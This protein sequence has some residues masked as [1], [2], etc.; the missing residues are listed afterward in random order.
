MGKRIEKSRVKSASISLGATSFLLVLFWPAY[1][2]TYTNYETKGTSLRL[3]LPQSSLREII[4][5]SVYVASLEPVN[6][7]R[8][9]L[10]SVGFVNLVSLVASRLSPIATT[11]P[12]R[13]SLPLFSRSSFFFDRDAI[14]A[15]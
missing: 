14:I 4:I 5:I 13:L 12:L 3:M 2:V 9:L 1:V 6:L 10:P 8:K 7:R 15:S 11:P